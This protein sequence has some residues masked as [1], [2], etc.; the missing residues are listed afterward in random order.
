LRDIRDAFDGRDRMFSVELV[1]ALT[2]TPKPNGATSG[3]GTSTR[4]AWPVY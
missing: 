3:G 4:T 1:K 2:T